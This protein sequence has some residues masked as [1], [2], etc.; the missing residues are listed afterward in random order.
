MSLKD[1]IWNWTILG[2]VRSQLVILYPPGTSWMI[3]IK[4]HLLYINWLPNQKK[5]S[6]QNLGP[7][8]LK[9]RAPLFVCYIEKI[10]PSWKEVAKGIRDNSKDLPRLC[11][12]FGD[13][14]P[15]SGTTAPPP[16]H[17]LNCVSMNGFSTS[18]K[19]SLCN[20]VHENFIE[21][22]FDRKKTNR[23]SDERII[24]CGLRSNFH[25]CFF[26]AKK[27]SI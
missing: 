6:R 1:F 8:H 24:G 22:F 15:P 11:M 9:S 17:R 26:N 21:S 23:Q 13:F 2:P 12:A 4:L 25:C 20:D 18:G 7:W 14:W 16:I 10:P 3:L 27:M 5:T 19:V